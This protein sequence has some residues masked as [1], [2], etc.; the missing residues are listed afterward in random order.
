[1]FLAMMYQVKFAHQ[2]CNRQVNFYQRAAR[3]LLCNHAP[4][5]T[6]DANSVANGVFDGFRITQFHH[7]IKIRQ[8][9]LQQVVEHFAGTGTALT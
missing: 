5:E 3:Q 7:Q 9:W 8:L 6:A 1:M 4:G 2:W